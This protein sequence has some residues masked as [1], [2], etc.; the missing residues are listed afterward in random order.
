[1]VMVG[2]GCMEEYG[3][4]QRMGTKE[5]TRWLQCWGWRYRRRPGCWSEKKGCI[6][7]HR[8]V[9]LGEVL[10]WWIKM[11]GR[12]YYVVKGVESRFRS[13]VYMHMHTL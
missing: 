3:N 8:D 10:E 9:E 6:W 7:C 2:G 12:R 5:G 13:H 11:V 1:M 4:L